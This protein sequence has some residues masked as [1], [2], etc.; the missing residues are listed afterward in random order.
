MTLGHEPG[1]KYRS[2]D[3]R[4]LG[5]ILIAAGLVAGFLRG[6]VNPMALPFSPQSAVWHSTS[7]AMWAL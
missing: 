2:E 3:L 5:L 7:S 4:K 6:Q 1:A